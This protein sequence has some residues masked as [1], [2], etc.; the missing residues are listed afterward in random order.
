MFDSGPTE[1]GV[2]GIDI[3]Q[4]VRWSGAAS[5]ASPVTYA[6]T[7]SAVPDSTINTNYEAHIFLAPSVGVGNPD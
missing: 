3:V 1:G 5:S 7:I 6:M 2:R 4:D